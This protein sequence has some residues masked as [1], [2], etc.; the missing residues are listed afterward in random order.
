MSVQVNWSLVGTAVAIPIAMTVLANYARRL[1]GAST[2]TG[3]DIVL[4]VIGADLGILALASQAAPFGLASDQFRI[5]LILT[6]LLGAFL[7]LW[8]ADLQAAVDAKAH[9]DWALSHRAGNTKREPPETRPFSAGRVRAVWMAVQV[10]L[11]AH[12]ATLFYL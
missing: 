3:G 11:T 4:T 12:V 9:R 8:S 7:F 6:C 2:S 1:A 5:A 10:F